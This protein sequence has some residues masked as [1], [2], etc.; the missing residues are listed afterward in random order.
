MNNFDAKNSITFQ[1]A[2]VVV[3]VARTNEG[4]L[5]PRDMW[6]GTGLEAPRVRVPVL[7]A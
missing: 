2:S 5:R 1:I 7:I 6:T 3:L 4:L